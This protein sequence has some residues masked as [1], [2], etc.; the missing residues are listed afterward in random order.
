MGG[1]RAA[2]AP[3]VLAGALLPAI[4]ADAASF[5]QEGRWITPDQAGI[6]EVA[7]CGN[8][9]CGIIAWLKD[10]LGED[11]RPAVD[12]SNPKAEL[13]QRPL[14]GLQIMGGFKPAANG[15]W[16]DG[17]I[18]DPET[19]KTYT[20]NV[21]MEGANLRLRGYV[22]IPLFGETQLWSRAPAGAPSC[23]PG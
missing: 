19:G 6:V 20:A 18:Y 2:Y 10:P 23:K 5:P 15:G 4:H 7:A 13:R 16:E 11:G 3:L 9:L 8:S 12:R 21:S 14:C 1:V 22:G 17:W